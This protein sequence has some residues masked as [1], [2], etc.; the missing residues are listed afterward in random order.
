MVPVLPLSA[1][2]IDKAAAAIRDGGLVVIPTDTVYGLACDPFSPAAVGRLFEAKRR[3]G[4]PIPVL[5]GGLS[6]AEELVDLGPAGSAL[7]KM[8]WPG[9]LTIVAP[10]RRTVP[11]PVDQGTATLGVRVP[12]LPAIVDLIEKSGGWTTGTSANVSG[13]PSSKTAEEAAAQLG[14]AVDMVLDGGTLPGAAST[15]VSVVGGSV[16]ILRSGQVR[17]PDALVR[18]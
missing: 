11:R 18:R 17:V 8:F 15:V 13:N 7:A 10:L 9:A 2:S 5:C 16:A 14:G 4:K 1:R 12:G 6:R 3:E